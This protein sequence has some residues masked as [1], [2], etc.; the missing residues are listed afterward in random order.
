MESRHELIAALVE[1]RRGVQMPSESTDT[2]VAAKLLQMV[3]L[4]TTAAEQKQ[5][6]QDEM[7]A[8]YLK[9]LEEK[10]NEASSLIEELKSAIETVNSIE[11]RDGKDADE[12]LVIRKVLAAIPAPKIPKVPA[13]DDVVKSV[14]AAIPT[15]V[16]G[17]D[18]KDAEIDEVALLDALI[19]RIKKDKPIDI[20]HIRNSDQFI[21][22]GTKY[23][24]SELMHGGGSSSTS[25][26]TWYLGEHIT[27]AGDNETFVLAHAPT[28][29]VNLYLDRQVQIYSLDFTGTI[30]GSNKTFAFT[31]PVDA[32]LLGEVYADYL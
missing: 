1:K 32:S 8:R 4:I 23:K 10:D 21:F 12:E 31:S 14:L 28:S 18:G 30:D 17:T 3:S 20:S 26:G 25:S 13:K 19:E 11:I 7:S 9:I 2:L 6:D 5:K 15:P 24:T 16:N 22:A 29:V 27:L